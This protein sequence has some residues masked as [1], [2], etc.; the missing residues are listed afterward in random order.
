[1]KIF[2][3]IA[4]VFRK[5]FPS[6][7]KY[8][9]HFL[10]ERDVTEAAKQVTG[11]DVRHYLQ[12]IHQL[13]TQD[14]EN[15]RQFAKHLCDFFIAFAGEHKHSDIV[16]R[17]NIEKI[18]QDMRMTVGGK[19]IGPIMDTMREV[20]EDTRVVRNRLGY[21]PSVYV[22]AAHC[23]DMIISLLVD[24]EK[25][26]EQLVI[27]RYKYELVA[28]ANILK[29]SVNTSVESTYHAIGVNMHCMS[30]L[31]YNHK[32]SIVTEAYH[33]LGRFLRIYKLTPEHY[34]H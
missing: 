10:Y 18:A 3:V 6:E 23:A 12:H 11:E 2:Y 9:A 22:L 17:S 7:P 5:L 4:Y 8:S 24:L 28:L 32:I 34:I 21:F 25:E 26:S 30:D 14:K 27:D 19:A 13:L 20:S 1:M 16:V 33:R 29:E 31:P 15:R